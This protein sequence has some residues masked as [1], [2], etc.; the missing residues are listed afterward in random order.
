MV[1][2][3]AHSEALLFLG[4]AYFPARPLTHLNARCKDFR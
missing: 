1:S 2:Q 4:S 3:E